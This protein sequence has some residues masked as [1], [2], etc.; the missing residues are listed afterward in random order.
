MSSEKAYSEEEA[1]CLW[2][3]YCKGDRKAYEQLIEVCY[4][5]LFQYGTKFTRDHDLIKDSIQDLFL[6][7]WKK[8]DNLISIKNPLSYLFQSLRYILIG[9]V[10]KRFKLNDISAEEFL[11]F[12]TCSYESDWIEKET[13]NVLNAH[14]KKAMHLLPERQREALYLRY[15]ENLSYEEIAEIMGLKRQAV[16]N[17]LQ[18]GIQKLRE[19]WEIIQV[20]VIGFPAVFTF[21]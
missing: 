14:L 7:I 4:K 1:I 11:P 12:E 15:Y 18:Y 10:K 8:S 3:Q 16:A 2:N 5:P 13:E 19:Y 21:F 6:S 17:Y 9:Q 20:F